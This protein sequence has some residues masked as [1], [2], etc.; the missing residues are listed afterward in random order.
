MTAPRIDHNLIPHRQIKSSIIVCLRIP[1]CFKSKQNSVTFDLRFCF[2]HDNFQ[3]FIANFYRQFDQ[4]AIVV[5]IFVVANTV[6]VIYIGARERNRT[7]EAIK[8]KAKLS[9]V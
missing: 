5:I 8:S 3:N 6:M 1:Y 9:I 7:V 2:F 4:L